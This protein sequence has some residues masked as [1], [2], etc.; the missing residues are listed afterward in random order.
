MT[1]WFFLH[2]PFSTGSCNPLW[3]K[4]IVKN[5]SFVYSSSTGSWQE[6]QVWKLLG[7]IYVA[8]LLLFSKL[9]GLTLLIILYLIM[10]TSDVICCSIINFNTNYCSQWTQ[11][12]V[13]LCLSTILLPLEE[14]KTTKSVHMY[15]SK[16]FLL[17]IALGILVDCFWIFYRLLDGKNNEHRPVLEEAKKREV[18]LPKN[19]E[20]R[21]C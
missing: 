15:K 6:S 14:Y 1:I 3:E 17:C 12:S 21:D 20:P 18:T 5:F 10:L 13:K 2:F 4:K 9:I 11:N 8:L 16:N 19:T 7:L